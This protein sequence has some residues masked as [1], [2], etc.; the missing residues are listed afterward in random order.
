MIPMHYIAGNISIKN[1]IAFLEHGVYLN[2]EVQQEE[3]KKFEEKRVIVRNIMGKP[4]K[5]FYLSK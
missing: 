3:L 5:Y 4:I 1:A 2:P